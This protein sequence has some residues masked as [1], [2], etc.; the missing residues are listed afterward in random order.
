VEPFIQEIARQRHQ[1]LL[2]IAE[3]YRLARVVRDSKTP[4][5]PTSAAHTESKPIPNAETAA[6]SGRPVR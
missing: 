6:L 4:H 5:W 2:D 1:D 3:R